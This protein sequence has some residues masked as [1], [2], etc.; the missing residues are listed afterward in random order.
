MEH[1]HCVR[2]GSVSVLASYLLHTYGR[3]CV[4]YLWSIY[5]WF[6]ELSWAALFTNL[7]RL[8]FFPSGLYFCS[9]R[10]CA[11]ASLMSELALCALQKPSQ[12]NALSTFRKSQNTHHMLG[13]V[14]WFVCRN[15]SPRCACVCVRK[16][17]DEIEMCAFGRLR[18]SVPSSP[19]RNARGKKETIHIDSRPIGNACLLSI[20]REWDEV[21]CTN[22]SC[23]RSMIPSRALLWE[24]V[25]SVRC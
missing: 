20:F 2:C 15:R 1:T 23:S 17:N 13:A 18:G 25:D 14:V 10:C 4:I 3:V 16:M 24:G 6:L 7:F 22:V 5:I 9:V 21:Q 8:L 19:F 11:A 12:Y